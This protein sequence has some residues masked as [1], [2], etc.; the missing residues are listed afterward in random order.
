MTRNV[1]AIIAIL[2]CTTVAWTILGGSVIS[3][4]DSAGSS[5]G[6]RVGSIWGKPQTQT[7]P[8]A[9]TTHI[10]P[11]VIE[12]K[13]N[14]VTVT[15]TVNET[16]TDVLPLDQTRIGVDLDLEQRQ[17]G[18]L[19]FATYRVAFKGQYVF[20]NADGSRSGDRQAPVSCP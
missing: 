1:L 4:T 10:V 18:L 11:H 9:T 2:L 5:L 17:K 20:R 19:W 15:K 16:V 12:E 6:E 3:R 8:V 14:G 7:P 13:T